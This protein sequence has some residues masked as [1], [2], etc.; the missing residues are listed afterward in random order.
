MSELFLPQKVKHGAKKRVVKAGKSYKKKVGEFE[1]LRVENT[2][3]TQKKC[4]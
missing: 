1:S 3:I 2:Y 4:P